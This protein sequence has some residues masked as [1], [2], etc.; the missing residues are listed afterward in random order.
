MKYCDHR[1][2]LSAHISQKPHVQNARDF[3]GILPVVVAR[4]S[5]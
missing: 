4:S 2:C 5:S 1:V 3:L